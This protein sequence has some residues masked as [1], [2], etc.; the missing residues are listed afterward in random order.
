M[1]EKKDVHSQNIQ[2]I[3]QVVKDEISTSIEIDTED[4]ELDS[5]I[6]ITEEIFHEQKS[7]LPL[8]LQEMQEARVCLE[9]ADDRVSANNCLLKLVEVEEK[10]SGKS[11]KDQ[12]VTIWTDIAKEKKLDEL[13]FSIMDMKRR[14]SCIRRSQNFVDLS[15]C[16]Q[17]LSEE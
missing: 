4:I 15:Q 13:E 12:E 17:D 2:K 5:G 16:M 1:K 8:L 6:E 10:I 11:S 7:L 9:Y 3:K 14:M